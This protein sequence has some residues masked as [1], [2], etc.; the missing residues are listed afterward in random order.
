MYDALLDA[1]IAFERMDGAPIPMNIC[2]ISPGESVHVTTKLRVATITSVHRVESQGYAVFSIK[3][4]SLRQELSGL[5]KDEIRTL[6]L[7][8]ENISDPDTESLE[9][10]YTGDTTIEMFKLPENEFILSVPKLVVELTY[11]DGD[12]AKASQRGHIHIEDIIEN[13]AMFN[14]V[15]ELIFVHFSQKYSMSQILGV[16]QEKLPATLQRKVKCSLHSFGAA[17]VLTALDDPRYLPEVT[18]N[19]VGWGWGLQGVITKGKHSKSNGGGLSLP[20]TADSKPCLSTPPPP[21]P[22]PSVVN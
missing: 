13:A 10:V 20:D 1:K 5:S 2:K 16:L 6:K 17:E 12:R 15:Q 18:S 11:I 4:G 21:P 8:G 14:A 3:K 7:S 9:F 22:P 19:I